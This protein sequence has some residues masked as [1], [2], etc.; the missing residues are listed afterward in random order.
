MRRD[1]GLE[2][3][4]PEWAEVGRGSHRYRR[5]CRA[6]HGFPEDP[7]E[8]KLPDSCAPV[9][10]LAA[11]IALL[12]SPVALA[13]D[14]GIAPASAFQR[15]S[16]PEGMQP[17][18]GGRY[19]PA[20][21]SATVEV[22]GFC[23]DAI[24]V[25]ASGFAACVQANACSADELVCGKAAT[26][27]SPGKGSHPINCV[28]W[29]DADAFCRWQGKR[30]P[31]DGEWEWAARGQ[32]RGSR[33]PW[34][35]ASPG[36]RACW[37]G[38]GNDWGAGLRGGPCPVASHLDGDS[39][40]GLHDLAGNVREWTMTGD[41][42]ERTIRGGSWGDSRDGLLA[43]GFRGRN[44]PLERFEATGFRCAADAVPQPSAETRPGERR[45]RLARA[46]GAGLASP[47]APPA[48]RPL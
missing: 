2:I 11:S 29:I 20:D 25:T 28:S 5:R 7:C 30:L 18:A 38:Q 4:E 19:T 45:S 47:G 15:P 37:D 39:P 41:W 17:L 31:T 1:D 8:S 33:Y 35:D 22:A 36:K 26:F 32:S 6:R 10:P 46:P 27:G 13:R 3:L 24:E 42:R 48:R 16:C 43:A 34:G 40:D 44:H 23:L 9:A 21:G 14:A 12:A